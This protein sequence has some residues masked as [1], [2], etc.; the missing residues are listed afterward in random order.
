VLRWI[1][2]YLILWLCTVIYRKHL[3]VVRD[4]YILRNYFLCVSSFDVRRS[5]MVC[6]NSITL[7]VGVLK[8]EELNK[9][10]VW[11]IGGKW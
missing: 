6:E 7:I 3:G 8:V 10:I 2:A 9:S 5:G 11:L 1:S 4:I